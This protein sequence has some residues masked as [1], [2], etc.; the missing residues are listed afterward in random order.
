M[1][2]NN[3]AFL[4][5]L[6]DDRTGAVELEP[7]VA[8]M[9]PCR[10]NRL[11]YG[12]F[13]WVGNGKENEPLSIGVER[14]TISDLC[15]SITTG[16][17]S[18]HQLLGLL[19]TYSHVT[20]LLEGIWRS[21]PQDGMLEVYRG[22]TW[23]PLKRGPTRWMAN[24]IYNYLNTLSM[25]CGVKVWQTGTAVES[26][27]WIAALYR[28]S[29]KDW[30]EHRSLHQFCEIPPRGARARLTA[31]TLVH[32]IAGEFKGV[33]F[34]RGAKIAGRFATPWDFLTASEAELTEI[35]GIGPKLA[36]SIVKEING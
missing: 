35:E 6:V 29:Q 31:P 14:K 32:R 16:R 19:N 9:A 4:M 2:R 7:Y 33:G 26:A 8:K 24:T 10:I 28:W 17:L 34:D 23:A 22:G 15:S 20:I 3:G 21:S 1:R 18:G 25:M 13:A 27:Q 36:A 5:I 12:D 30:H 11:E